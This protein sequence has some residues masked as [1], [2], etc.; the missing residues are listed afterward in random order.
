MHLFKGHL[1]WG[2]T[3]KTPD[4]QDP[5]FTDPEKTCV[6]FLLDRNLLGPGSVGIR[7]HSMFDGL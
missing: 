5:R 1:F 4:P 3:C 2:Y 6:S 7:S